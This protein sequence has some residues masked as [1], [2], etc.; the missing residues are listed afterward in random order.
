MPQ[1]HTLSSSRIEDADRDPRRLLT[2][3]RA[4]RQSQAEQVEQAINALLAA[5]IARPK[6]A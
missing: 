3:V 6:A 1:D 4:G 5:V 2:E